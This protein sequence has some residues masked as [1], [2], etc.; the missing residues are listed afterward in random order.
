MSLL[1]P[2]LLAASRSTRARSLVTAVRPTR[3]VVQ[4]FVAGET[5][6]A[7][8]AAI[9]SLVADGLAVTVDH[10]GEDT[11]DTRQAVATADAYVALLG[12]LADEGL[13]ART[14]VSIKPSALGLALD[15]A[16]GL[17]NA[18]RICEAAAAAG[19]TVSVDMEGSATV[20]ATLGLVRDLRADFGW[21][22]A[23]VQ[24]MLHRTEADCRDLAVPGSRVRLVKGAYA[25]PAS[26]AHQG[27]ADVDAAY[28]RCLSILMAGGG[29]PMVGSHDPRMIS[30]ALDLAAANGRAASSFEFQ[31]LYGVRAGEQR[32]LAA[33]GNTVRVYLPYGTDWYGYFM[34]RLAERPANLTFF[35]RS[36]VPGAN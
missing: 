31:M 11:T 13:T 30:S 28:Q 29:Y 9:H 7:A 2:A 12:R 10:L 26:V 17:D 20:D 5:E 8:V 4:R 14:E 1:S 36:F 32:R 27:T 35:L 21:V 33:E 16:L 15:P 24:A 34:R 22:G 18:R 19:T 25:E 23:V 3:K 6:Q